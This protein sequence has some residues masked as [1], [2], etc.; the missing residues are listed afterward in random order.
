MADEVE[1]SNVGGDNGVA[2]EATLASLTRAIEKLAASTGRDPKKEAGKVQK[3]HNDAVKN[4]ITVSTKYGDSLKKKTEATDKAT[5]ATNRYSRAMIGF[6]GGLL[7]SV[8]QSTLELGKALLDGGSS[9]TDFAQHLPLVGN[10][11]AVF[12]QVIDQNIEAV[13]SMSRVGATFGDGLT[14]IRHIA[15]Q[16][17]MPLSDFVDLVNSN[18]ESMKLF[19]SSTATGAA[20]F[21]ALSRELRQGPGRALMNLGFTSTELNE[22]LIDYAELQNV[23]F[24]RDRIQGRITSANAAAFGEELMRI[25]AITGKRREQIEAELRQAAGDIRVRA[26]LSRMD[27]DQRERFQLNIADIGTESQ[28][29][30]NAL[31][32]FSDGIPTNEVTRR[33]MGF[34]DTFRNFGQ[35]IQNMN[36]SELN[37]FVVGVREDLEAF[38]KANQMTTEELQ[39]SVPGLQEFFGIISETASRRRLSEQEIAEN[40]RRLA[41]E[42]RNGEELM[43]FSET[44]NTIRGEL[45][46]AFIESG[47]LD[48]V[49][50]LLSSLADTLSDFVRDPAFSEGLARIAT[51]INSFIHNFQDFDL[52]T[53]ILGNEDLGVDGLFDS[54]MFAGIGDAISSALT[55]A[56]LASGAVIAGGIVAALTARSV[57]SAVGS[58]ISNAF[59][60]LFNSGG[61]PAAAA[62]PRRRGP[63]VGS[64]AGSA[65]GSFLGNMGGGVMEGAA[66]GLKAFAYPKILL[67]AGILGA[68]ITAIGAGIAGA[69]WL[70]GSALPTLA[71][72]LSSLE[73]LNAEKLISVGSAMLSLAGGL[74]AF[75]GANIVSAIGNLF[76]TD[77]GLAETAR[78]LEA[79]QNFNVDAA[80]VENNARAMVAFGTAMTSFGTGAALSGIGSVVSAIGNAIANFFGGESPLEQLQSFGN[81]EINSEGVER[82]ANA[83]ASFAEA[84]S[85]MAGADFSDVDIPGRLVSRLEDLSQITGAGLTVTAEGMQAIANVEG[86]QT[87]LDILNRGLDIDRVN[88]YAEAMERLVETLD[89]LN[90]VLAEDNRG[91]FGGGTGVA[92]ADVLGQINTAS[93]GSSEGIMQLNR[94]MSQVLTVLQD[95]AEDADQ[96]ERNT[97][98]TGSNIANGRVSAVR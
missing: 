67:G 35:D 39:N 33:L 24:T 3:A 43:Q 40:E 76:Q 1:I 21:A 92:A 97:R 11:L 60:G 49:Q 75:G 80:R 18:S 89:E 85:R 61:S 62:G 6:I 46:N 53:A 91:A 17:A 81:A 93:T 48:L 10:Y 63:G 56:L 52:L 23:A 16:A 8:T 71:E 78:H 20:N 14:E 96:I 94:L 74:A 64:Q 27:E 42:R 12:T 4:G 90:D 7:G 87:N 69:T 44:M 86:L 70:M 84:L 2:S 57:V 58:G 59:S 66:R 31:I 34:S 28:A 83:M 65:L 77:E 41:L 22:L 51:A 15:A 82:N 95:M 19:G 37:N 55:T 5:A 79:F 13:R 47:V 9:L 72:G 30:A 29:L 45:M 73:T 25:T 32:D 68:S 54:D 26:A 38:A 98:S 50:G 36:T 88:D